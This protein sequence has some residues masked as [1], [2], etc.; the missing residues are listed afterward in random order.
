MK[1]FF[2]FRKPTLRLNIMPRT[3]VDWNDKKKQTHELYFFLTN[4]WYLV[5]CISPM[6]RP[7]VSMEYWIISSWMHRI[8]HEY[9][10]FHI[11]FSWIQRISIHCWLFM[12]F[13][14][15]S[16]IFSFFVIF[17][18]LTNFQFFFAFS[19]E[20][21]KEFSEQ[22]LISVVSWMEAFIQKSSFRKN[23]K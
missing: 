18:F 9:T 16:W 22:S 19:A 15:F 11:D 2:S 3:Y 8:F 20:I 12:N 23:S 5:F 13:L 17:Q 7:N 6:L 1:N 10:N 4:A 21:S 14:V